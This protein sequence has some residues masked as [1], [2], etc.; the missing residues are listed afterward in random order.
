MT[1]QKI[2]PPIAQKAV[3]PLVAE[4][5]GCKVQPKEAQTGQTG[6]AMAP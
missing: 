4:P 6:Q 5:F 3:P 1:S 2:N